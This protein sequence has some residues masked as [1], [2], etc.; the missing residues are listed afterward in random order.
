MATTNYDLA[1]LK[2]RWWM[3]RRYQWLQLE[4]TWYPRLLKS[5]NENEQREWKPKEETELIRFLEDENEKIQRA[6]EIG[7][8][9]LH[10]ILGQ[11]WENNALT[12]TASVQS[13]GISSHPLEN[14]GDC[15]KNLDEIMLN[16]NGDSQRHLQFYQTQSNQHLHSSPNC[17]NQLFCLDQA[18]STT[19]PAPAPCTSS[20]DNDVFFDP[21]SI[22]EDGTDL[23][24]NVEYHHIID[25]NIVISAIN[26]VE[27]FN[28]GLPLQ[29]RSSI[30]TFESEDIAHN[31][32]NWDELS[33]HDQN[34]FN[35]ELEKQ[36]EHDKFFRSS[37]M[38]IQFLAVRHFLSL[39][40]I[41]IGT[42][43]AGEFN[44]RKGGK[45]RHKK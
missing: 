12:R 30:S 16:E 38:G 34:D 15:T 42:R 21:D 44:I 9:S 11:S 8:S 1:E 32:T 28:N 43:R 39:V 40:E 10:N 33:V 5:E 45:L 6:L 23:I 29:R 27:H 17:S 22:N 20:E 3:I 4:T 37:G 14:Y 7:P 2:H 35:D 26:N 36:L 18:Y 25:H 41:C 31:F 13:S 24:N 19:A